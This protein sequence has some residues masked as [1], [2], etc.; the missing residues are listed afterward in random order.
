MA[1]LGS[2]DAVTW[3]GLGLLLTLVGLIL[4]MVIWRRRGMAAGLRMTAW[5][6]LPLAA[7]LTG[8][9]RL[10]AELIGSIGRWATRLVFS[11][12]VWLGLVVLGLALVLFVLSGLLRRRSAGARPASRDVSTRPATRPVT[13]PVTGPA[14]GPATSAATSSEDDEVEAILRRHGIS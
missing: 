7:G 5:S 14:T 11:P 4:S 1:G 10:I 8:T 12:T 9:L 13:R 6:L 2:V 3:Q